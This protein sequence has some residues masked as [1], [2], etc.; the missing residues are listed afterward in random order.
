MSFLTPLYIA[1]LAAVALPALFHLFRRTPRGRVFF[2]TLMFLQPSP[3]RVTRR[4]RIEHWPLLM[5]RALALCLI[6]AAFARPFWREARRLASAA[7]SGRTVALL[8]DTSASMRREGLW[9]QALQRAEAVLEQQQVHDRLGVFAFDRDFRPVLSFEEAAALHWA[10]ARE[11]ARRRLNALSPGWAGTN[12]GDA[13]A[14]V[15]DLLE[16][17][18]TAQGSTRPAEIVLIS[19]LQAGSRLDRLEQ[20]AWPSTLSVRMECL[21]AHPAGNAGLHLAIRPADHLPADETD[22]VRVCVTNTA[23]SDREQFRLEWWAGEI[24]RAHV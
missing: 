6:A 23:D 18:R 8:I 19:D 11:T 1:G 13:L 21:A 4:S 17:F 7:K 3:P 10:A 22:A 5:L 16:A 24:G 15:A 14:G 12:L 9:A 2:S 20:Y